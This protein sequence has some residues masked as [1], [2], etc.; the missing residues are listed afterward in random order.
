MPDRVVAIHQPEHMP[1]LGF[2]DKALHADLFVLLDTVQFR[3]NY[4]QNRNKIRTADGSC[5]VTLPVKPPLVAPIREIRIEQ[6]SPL[7]QRYVRLLSTHYRQAPCLSTYLSAISELVLSK[8]ERLAEI[9]VALIRFVCD[10]LG[11][12][13]RMVLAS[14]LGLPPATGGTQVNLDICRAVGATTYLSGVS[15]REYL[16][17]RVFH[18]AGI[19]VRFQEFHHPVYRQCYEP[20]VPA[21]SCVDLLFNYGDEAGSLLASADV[22]RLSTLFA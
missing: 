20:F 16:D 19:E 1:W 14:E 21:L 12:R 11:I 10:A 13:T 22:P 3:K 7:R 8:T 6:D 9:N 17:Q 5:W 4:F 18:E 2:L 15:G